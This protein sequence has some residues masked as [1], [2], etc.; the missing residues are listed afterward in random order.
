MLPE[1]LVWTR[2]LSW[3][4]AS[5]A[6]LVMNIAMFLGALLLGEAVTR[7]YHG[8]PVAEPPLPLRSSES[9]LAA[10]CVVL[11]AAV[12]W[13]GWALFRAGWVEVEGDAPVW[14]WAVDAALLVVVMD[15]AM[16]VAHRIAHAPAFYRHVHAVHHRYD[17]PRPLTLFVL[18]PVEVIGFGSLWIAV[19]CMR[20]FS[21]GGMFIYLSLNIAFGL[22]GHT[23]VEPLPR[24]W[25]DWP[26]VKW[27]GT[28]TFHARHHQRPDSNYGFYTA[29]WDRLFGSLDALYVPSFARP[30]KC[31]HSRPKPAGAKTESVGRRRRQ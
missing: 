16:Y 4:E 14:R 2:S 24:G 6:S 29:I 30:L 10:T 11:N 26:I 20:P 9:I 8:V 1:L 19:L 21:L 25:V 13:A 3:L 27:L 28:S 31:D 5:V 23:G 12:M 17:R 18:H 22:L 7:R 15:F